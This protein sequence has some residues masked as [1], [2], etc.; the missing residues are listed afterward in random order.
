MRL[1]TIPLLACAIAS[2][3]ADHRR[4]RGL[5]DAE[6]VVDSSGASPVAADDTDAATTASSDNSDSTSAPITASAPAAP[7]D[8][9]Q[10][11]VAATSNDGDEI[12]SIG[13]IGV[14]GQVVGGTFTLA[15]RLPS[16]R[17][18]Y[19]RRACSP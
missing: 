11:S 4:L 3:S 6:S 12:I 7:T 19:G 14:D 17:R 8:A 13:I 15:R 9:P 16:C 5:S 2:V 18:S 10:A 1:R